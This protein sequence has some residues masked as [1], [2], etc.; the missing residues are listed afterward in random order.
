MLAGARSSR[1]D[2]KA[3]PGIQTVQTKI[4]VPLTDFWDLCI[5]VL[6]CGPVCVIVMRADNY[7]TDSIRHDMEN[8][9]FIST[10]HSKKETPPLFV[11]VNAAKEKCCNVEMPVCV[12]LISDLLMVFLKRS[13]EMP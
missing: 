3:T 6:V 11:I 2:K 13:R 10:Q 8:I 1:R 9:A 12:S 5:Y 4:F 7:A